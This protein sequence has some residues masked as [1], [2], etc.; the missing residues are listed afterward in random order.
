MGDWVTNTLREREQEAQGPGLGWV[1][2]Q[3]QQA[4]AEAE[5]PG[6]PQPPPAEAEQPNFLERFIGGF[7]N[8]GDQY[9]LGP[10][11]R[12]GQPDQE[13]LDTVN[14]TS[15]GALN[16]A[17]ANW[18]DEAAGLVGG[19]PWRDA[20][21]QRVALARERS[22]VGSR[23]GEAGGALATGALLPGAGPAA[24]LA[25]AATVG[26]AN[27]GGAAPEGHR[28]P[29]AA[30]G[31]L[32]GAATAGVP[33]AAGVAGKALGNGMRGLAHYADSGAMAEQM[34]RTAAYTMAAGMGT[35]NPGPAALAALGMAGGSFVAPQAVAAAGVPMSRA[36]S[37][38]GNG[39]GSAAR[40]LSAGAAAVGG[41]SLGRSLGH[42]ME[43]RL[44]Q[45]LQSQPQVLGDYATELIEANDKG[46]LG[47]AIDRLEQTDEFFRTNIAPQIKGAR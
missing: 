2:Q 9:G 19:D 3:L 5:A 23:I 20:V 31:G 16:G 21:R 8:G 44:D 15:V 40:T 25:R 28:I 24:T 29:A 4:V 42:K 17:T 32:Q 37:G 13:T 1:Q 7:G 27:A 14:D 43:Q 11:A 18:G 10:L 38:F 33:M 41:E 39:V 12:S 45:I 30:M 46:S 36:L 47:A 22:P 26:A 34:R 35:G 6:A